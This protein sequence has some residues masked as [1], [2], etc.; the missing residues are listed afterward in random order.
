M[1]QPNIAFRGTHARK[2]LRQWSQIDSCPVDQ[3]W[4]VSSLYN[5]SHFVVDRT[6][7]QLVAENSYIHTEHICWKI[8]LRQKFEKSDG[9]VSELVHADADDTVG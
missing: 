8:S 6:A 2:Y 7:F 9:Q 4:E 1:A 3:T 5:Q